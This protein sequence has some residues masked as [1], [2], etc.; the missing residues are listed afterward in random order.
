MFLGVHLVRVTSPEH[1]HG[2]QIE[3]RLREWIVGVVPGACKSRDY[4][5]RKRLVDRV[6]CPTALQGKAPLFGKFPDVGFQGIHR[7]SPEALC[8]GEEKMVKTFWRV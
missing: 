5:L 3:M 2:R 8:Y 6:K 4:G 7:V 1:T